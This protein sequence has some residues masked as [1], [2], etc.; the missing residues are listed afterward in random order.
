MY[1]DQMPIIQVVDNLSFNIYL[2][3]FEVYGFETVVVK[4]T[5][6]CNTDSKKEMPSKFNRYLM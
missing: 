1:T 3:D 4:T 2:L 5:A 6:S